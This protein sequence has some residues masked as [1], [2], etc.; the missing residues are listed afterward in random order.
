MVMALE[1]AFV[2]HRRPYRDSSLIVELLTRGHGRISAL[3]RGAR[4]SRSRYHG[5]LEPF[6]ALL[7]SWGGRGE[8]AT[9]H[10]AEENGAAATVLPPALLVHGFYLNELLLRLL[11]RH[12][13]CPEI[14]AAYGETLTALAGTT[15]SAIVQAR[16]RLFEKRLLEALGYGLNLQYDGREGAPIRPAQRYRYY[17]QRGAL[18]ITDDLGLQAH[19][20]GVE[21]QGE[22][23]IALAA[24]TLA[25]ATALR[26]SKRLM[27]MALNRLL[28]GR[29]LHSRELVRPG[30]RHDSDKEEA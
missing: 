10:Q 11:H 16:L 2:L 3:A 13:P 20:D 1:P 22:T 14:H 6:R 7:V 8:L 23:L 18:P 9:L 30:S 17:P 26:E 21:V 25:S 27:R 4:R 28:G 15:D 29:P 5:R 12:D 24:G 19:D